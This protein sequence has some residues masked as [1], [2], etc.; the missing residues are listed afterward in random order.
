VDFADSAISP[1]DFA[2]W[3]AVVI[4]VASLLLTVIFWRITDRRSRTPVL[5]F[6]NDGSGWRIR[7]IGIGPA[8]NVVVAK[9]HPRPDSDWGLVTNL[10]PIAKDA[11]VDISD[12]IGSAMVLAAQ[13]QDLRDIEG[14]GKGR[15]YLTRCEDNISTI[16][17]NDRLPQSVSEKAEPIWTR[18]G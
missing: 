8:L 13:Y 18:M 7:N 2:P 6:V 12:W 14:A 17:A 1:S 16:K 11:E 5:I 4:S 15:V 9:R 3:V 10:P